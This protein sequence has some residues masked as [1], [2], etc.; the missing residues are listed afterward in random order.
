MK[1]SVASAILD[2]L[3]V[4]GETPSPLVPVRAFLLSV[5]WRTEL[6]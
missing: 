3:K 6:R 2:R 1:A 5:N 4:M